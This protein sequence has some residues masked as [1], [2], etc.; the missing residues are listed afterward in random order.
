MKCIIVDDDEMSRKSLKLLCDKIDILDV[1]KSFTNGLEA[2]N[3]LKENDADLVF[4]DIEM[5]N[6]SGIDLVKNV[7]NLPQVIFV[8][9]HSKYALEAFEHQ[10]T[11][12][13]PKPVKL[14][15]LL[16]ATERA[17]ELNNN[18]QEKKQNDI[19]VRINGRFVRLALDD[20]LYIESLGDYVTFVTEQRKYIVHSTLKNINKKIRSD[21]FLKIHRSYIVN[22]SKVV[23][24]EET[25]LVV[26]EKVIPV[27]RANRPTLMKH[28]Q[29]M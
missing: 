7:E 1:T 8:T 28:I 29:T 13:I 20:V 2:I 25:N 6:L 26:A 5:P 9:S 24:I 10:V 14:P 11:D 18:V 17:A 21:K 15:R 3:W 27:S 22:M 16:K 4:L 23:D 12:F 19:Y